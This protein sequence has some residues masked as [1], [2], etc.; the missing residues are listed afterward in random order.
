MKKTITYIALAVALLVFFPIKSAHAI[1]INI[2][3]GLETLE[4]E[5][6]SNGGDTF[7]IEI[8]CDDEN[9]KKFW[10]SIYNWNTTKKKFVVE[11]VM[12]NGNPYTYSLISVFQNI[13]CEKNFNTKIIFCEGTIGNYFGETGPVPGTKNYVISF[14]FESP[15]ETPSTVVK[16]KSKR[17]YI[18]D[19]IDVTPAVVEEPTE[20]P[21]EDVVEETTDGENVD[22]DVDDVDSDGDKVP[23]SK[24]NCPSDYNPLQK[25]SDSDGLA[26]WCADNCRLVYNPDQ[27]DSDDD[28]FGDA[29]EKDADGDGIEDAKD[30]CVS[31]ANPGQENS[32]GDFRGDACSTK[33]AEGGEVATPPALPS[34]QTGGCSLASTAVTDAGT[35]FSIAMLLSSMALMVASRKK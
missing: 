28:G 27:K 15:Q 30:N 34:Y 25:D 21:V 6:G 5:N 2:I 22:D 29:C 12:G 4:Y 32:D 17:Y 16:V 10:S 9:W 8:Q 26:D 18:G 13:S 23:D 31:V 33:L 3:E 24:D 19:A 35:L 14:E 7:R 20:E 1:D 11:K